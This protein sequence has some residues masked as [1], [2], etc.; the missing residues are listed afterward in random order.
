MH[1]NAVKKLTFTTSFFK[2]VNEVE[3]ITKTQKK[4]KRMKGSCILLPHQVY[5]CMFREKKKKQRKCGYNC[6]CTIFCRVTGI[7]E[8][9]SGGSTETSYHTNNNSTYREREKN[10]VRVVYQQYYTHI[11]KGWKIISRK[12]LLSCCCCCCCCCRLRW[13]APQNYRERAE[14]T[15]CASTSLSHSL[16]FISILRVPL[17]SF[18]LLFSL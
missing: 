5:F 3:R 8:S 9:S 10:F 16:V 2:N 4:N 15:Q 6:S 7:M 14:I 13:P 17:W 12:L 18:A 1:L 11:T